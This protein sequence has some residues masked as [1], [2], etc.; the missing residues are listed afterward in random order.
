[1]RIGLHTSRIHVKMYLYK[2]E[3]YCS[4]ML[5]LHHSDESKEVIFIK[6]YKCSLKM[7]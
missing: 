7:S 5:Q 1:M 2:R 6:W 4:D 3:C